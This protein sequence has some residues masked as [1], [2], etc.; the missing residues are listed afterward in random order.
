[1][2]GSWNVRINVVRTIQ[3]QLSLCLGDSVVKT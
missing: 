1:M 2:R 3:F